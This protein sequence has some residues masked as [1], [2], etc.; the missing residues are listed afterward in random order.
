[1]TV[2]AEPPVITDG[3]PPQKPPEAPTPPK[4]TR[5][6]MHI[7]SIARST[8]E[9]TWDPAD[10]GSVAR[11]RAVFKDCRADGMLASKVVTPGEEEQ[12]KEFDP[13]AETIIFRAP[14][15]GG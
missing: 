11:A 12:L 8:R 4:T 13:E 15:Q 2:L 9:Q 1:M 6:V 5:H 7:V 10:K 14:L 3:P